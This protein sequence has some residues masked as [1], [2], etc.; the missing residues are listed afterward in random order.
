MEAMGLKISESNRPSDIENDQ[1][2]NNFIRNAK[3]LKNNLKFRRF[4]V[5][6]DCTPRQYAQYMKLKSELQERHNAGEP[7]L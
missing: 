1:I 6:F 2:V 3:K 5:V 7:N 4:S